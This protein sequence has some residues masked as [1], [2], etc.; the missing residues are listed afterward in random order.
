MSL[1]LALFGHGR[2]GRRCPLLGEE[3]KSHFRVVRAAFDPSET[4]PITKRILLDP[5]PKSSRYRAY[6]AN[7][8]HSDPEGGHAAARSSPPRPIAVPGLPLTRTPP[9]A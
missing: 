4:W 3:R 9:A 6:G 8:A 5:A 7:V 2:F 1:L